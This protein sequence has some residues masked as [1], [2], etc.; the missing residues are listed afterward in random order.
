M[1]ATSF[2]YKTEYMLFYFYAYLNNNIEQN[3]EFIFWSKALK[4]K[5]IQNCYWQFQFAMFPFRNKVVTV[6]DSAKR[7][8]RLPAM[9]KVFLLQVILSQST[10][11]EL[12]KAF[13]QLNIHSNMSANKSFSAQRSTLSMASYIPIRATSPLTVRLQSSV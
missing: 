10:I 5:I 11:M 6:L 13:Q 4:M 9:Q 12:K 7:T 8:L 1:T 2:N 3:M